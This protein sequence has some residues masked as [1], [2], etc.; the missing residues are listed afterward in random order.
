MKKLVLLVLALWGM[1]TSVGAQTDVSRYFLSNY[2]FDENFDY[3]AGQTFA[4]AQEILSI[5]GWTQGFSHNYTITGVY[6][7][8]FQG[9]FNGATVPSVGYDGEAGG[10]LVLS[11]GWET[12]FPY[13][14]EVTLPAGTYTINVPTYNGCDVTEGTSLLAWIPDGGT[15]VSS[16]VASY[17]A[18][19][20]TLDKISFTLTRATKGQIRIGFKAASYG[21]AN[22]AKLVID[23]VQIMGSNMTVDKTTL[24]DD[25]ETANSYYSSNGVGASD[26]KTLIDAAQTVYDDAS[27]TAYEIL[28]AQYELETAVMTFRLANATEG[29]GTG[30]EV[31]STNRYVPTGATSAL[32]RAEFSGDD[33]IEQGVCWSTSHNPTVLDNR[34]T[35]YYNVNGNMYH[36]TGL[37]PAT[38]YY[39][40]PYVIDNSYNVAY[41][42]EV[43][44]VT[45][46]TGTCK[47]TWNEGAPDDDANTRCRNAISNAISYVNEWTGVK[48][49]TLSGNYG[50]STQTA[51][52]SYGGYMRIGPNASYQATGTVLHETGHG[53]GVGTT[54]RWSSCSDTR[55]STSYGK[56]LGREANKMLQFLE[57]KEGNSDCYFTG[58]GT[59][60]WGNNA[61]YDWFI[62]GADKDKGS[63]I[64]YIGCSCLLYALFVDGLCP[65]TSYYNGVGGYTYNFDSEKKYYLMSKDSFCG[66][67][68]GLLYY[69]A[70]TLK[71]QSY[72]S[73]GS[74]DDAAAWY[75]EYDP[76]TGCY[77]FKNA[78]T[79]AYLTVSSNSAFQLMPDRT[80]VII[81]NDPN[82]IT[83]HGYWLTWYNSGNKSLA[84]TT[85]GGTSAATFDYSDAATKQQWIII[86][87]DELQDYVDAISAEEARWKDVTAD[88]GFVNPNFD[89][90]SDFQTTN[91][92]TGTTSHINCEGWTTTCTAEYGASAVF[93]V[94]SEY[95]LN[96]Q[97]VPSV[98]ANGEAS[99][100]ML[101]ISQGW[102]IDSK[103]SQTVQL[104]AGTYRFGYAVYNKAN[105][106]AFTNHCGYQIGS[107]SIVYDNSVSSVE[108][109]SWV[110]RTM[111]SFTI[112]ET[113]DVTF[114]VGM[115]AANTTSTNNPFLFFDY[116]KLESCVLAGDVNGDGIVSLAD[117][118]SLVNVLSG[119]TEGYDLDAADVNGDGDIDINDVEALVDLLMGN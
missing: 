21:S 119:D 66:L 115:Q 109:G 94:G 95:T 18:N 67:G 64:Q 8:G 86:S 74:V 82:G 101:G 69:S 13:T 111:Y 45:L 14:Q 108:V 4:V 114:Y 3:T 116:V 60:G 50:S 41:G 29:S 83:T 78:S 35:K 39:L 110:E 22:S 88:V 32:M 63:A 70:S 97:N 26:F 55:A 85:T 87:E 112:T 11:T 1:V 12:D 107:G 92:S 113:S 27:A 10:G 98:N 38:V 36:P 106:T 33:I 23:Y 77:K 58:D 91:L 100:G 9:T 44:I 2:G 62:N 19:D 7:F 89:T 99:G 30:L 52:C 71:W 75:M 56:W 102:S 40:R 47:G 76:S 54:T 15:T 81:G 103:Y 51:D 16:S 79:S 5:D 84:A 37:T 34:T 117:L 96:G 49:F 17:T 24:A 42:D 48:G 104:P 105:T 53:V 118:T 73:T 25:L 65:T 59:H 93:A 43:K 20:W 31:T 46:S 57:N 72:L 68:D 80:D 6:E 61:T 28:D 90:E